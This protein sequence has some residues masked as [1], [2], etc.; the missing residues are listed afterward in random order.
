VGPSGPALFCYLRHGGDCMPETLLDNDMERR[1]VH[2][3]GT[4]A[5]IAHLVEP[6]LDTL[7]F[8]LVRVRL[9]SR[10]GLTLQ[11]MLERKDGTV[12][13]EDCEE[14]SRAL[15]PLLD[16]EDP[17]GNA[18][19]LEVSSPGIDRP[20]V[21]VGDF[22]R[23]QGHLA[24]VETA[25]MLDGRKRFKGRIGA[26]DRDGFMLEA[27][28]AA[29]GESPEVRI[30]FEELGEVRLVLTDDLIREALRRDKE[31]RKQAKEFSGNEAD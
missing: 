25:H 29:Y 24:K 17:I 18:Y 7:G 20:L 14:A 5:R 6:L 3:T 28:K 9:S 12:T 21:T 31:L 11:I 13:V 15:S 30:P 2:E 19:H 22:V 27:E 10:E 26:V 23:W 4:D 16:V 8:R 1:V